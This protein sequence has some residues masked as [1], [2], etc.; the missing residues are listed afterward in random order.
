MYV[1]RHE[2]ALELSYENEHQL[3][4]SGYLM[5]GRRHWRCPSKIRARAGATLKG[6]PPV[7]TAFGEFLGRPSRGDNLSLRPRRAGSHGRLAE[8]VGIRPKSSIHSSDN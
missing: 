5:T 2:M 1:D 6:T 7:T 8:V 4:T 3:K